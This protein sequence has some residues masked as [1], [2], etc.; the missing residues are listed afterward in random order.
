MSES[1]ILG[2]RGGIPAP[3]PRLLR[4]SK[5]AADVGGMSPELA[6]KEAK[7]AAPGAPL[8]PGGTPGIPDKCAIPPG[9]PGGI[10]NQTRKYTS[11][12]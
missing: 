9:R 7:P 8:T 2:G 5:P 10:Y 12:L 6:A 4:A 3:A 1:L 11:L